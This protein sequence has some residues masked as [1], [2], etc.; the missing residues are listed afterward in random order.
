MSILKIFSELDEV[1][2]MYNIL[3]DENEALKM[4]IKILTIDRD[5]YKD[6]SEYKKP[7]IVDY[8]NLINESL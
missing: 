6:L 7:I 2:R 4:D 1:Q 5:H 8:K 3:K